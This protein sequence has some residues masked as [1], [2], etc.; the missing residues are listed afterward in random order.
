MELL[1]IDCQLDSSAVGSRLHEIRTDKGYSQDKLATDLG[2]D[3][4]YL[5]RL[6]NGKASPSLPLIKKF[7]DITGAS[8]DF[9]IYGD[10]PAYRDKSSV[11]HANMVR[12]TP[13][14]YMESLEKL[15]RRE[16]GMMEKIIP[17]IADAISNKKN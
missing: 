14:P 16:R 17:A 11:K 12:E 1:Q 8:M 15:N 3:P 4:K 7:C 10:R 5:S 2:C 13:A 6:E 9:L